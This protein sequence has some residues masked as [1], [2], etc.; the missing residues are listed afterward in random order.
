[1][2]PAPPSPAQ[3]PAACSGPPPL[4]GFRAGDAAFWVQHDTKDGSA[5]YFHLHTFQGT[6]ERPAGCRL[7]TSHLTREE[8][9]VGRAPEREGP[10]R[11][12]PELSLCL[13]GYHRLSPSPAVRCHQGHGRL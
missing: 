6:W 4:P 2:A 1:M 11:G 5:Y 3:P 9:Q 12:S 7:N 10:G 13:P 8:I